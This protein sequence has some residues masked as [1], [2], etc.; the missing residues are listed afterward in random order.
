MGHIQDIT[1]TKTAHTLGLHE[2]NQPYQDVNQNE[3]YDNYNYDEPIVPIYSSSRVAEVQHKIVQQL[4]N[5]LLD[6]VNE[7]SKVQ[8]FDLSKQL[9]TKDTIS[10]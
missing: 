6:K 9:P 4:G 2:K 8:D 5:D 3:A 7:E 1:N 10:E